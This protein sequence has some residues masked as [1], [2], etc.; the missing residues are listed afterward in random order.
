MKKINLYG[1]LRNRELIGSFSSISAAKKWVKK[2]VRIEKGFEL[3]IHEFSDLQVEC[4]DAPKCGY[5][6]AIGR[7]C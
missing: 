5:Y 7:R 1:G 2:H 3:F 4:N 6:Y